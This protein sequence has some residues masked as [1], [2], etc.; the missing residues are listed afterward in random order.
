MTAQNATTDLTLTVWRDS[1]QGGDDMDAPHEAKFTIQRDE[2]LSSVIDRVRSGSFLACV[3]GGAATWIAESGS[4]PLAVVAQQ[5]SQP[6]FLVTP[7]Q[8]VCSVL[9]GDCRCH[10]NFRY[11][12]QADP[13]RVFECLQQGKPLPEKVRIPVPTEEE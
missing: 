8:S 7:E 11:W 6:R 2:S 12:C 13:E 3:G 4:R 1:V 5:W 10:L 9:G